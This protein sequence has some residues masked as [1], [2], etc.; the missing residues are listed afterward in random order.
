[1]TKEELVNVTGLFTWLWDCHFHIET[2]VG[3]FLWSDPD[4][5]GDDTIRPCGTY[6]EILD[7]FQIDFGR[8]KGRHRIGDYTGETFTYVEKK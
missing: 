7:E 4:Y 5:N 2:D 3:N 8:E 1:M 6:A